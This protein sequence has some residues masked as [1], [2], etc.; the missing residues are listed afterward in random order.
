M[1]TTVA[2]QQTRRLSRNARRAVLIAHLSSAGAWLGVDLVMAVFIVR[3]GLTD[4]PAVRAQ[5][6]LALEVFA[7]W[8]LLVTGLVC[9]ATGVVLGLGTKWGLVRYWWVAAKLA[10]NVLLTGLVLVALRGQVDGAAG[11]SRLWLAGQPAD[12]SIGDYIYPPIVSPLALLVAFTLS[13]VKP[14]GRIR[15]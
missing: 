1:T 5:S 12:L 6:F 7:V 15:G 2:R 4:D 14:W 13:V 10:L 9:L 3:A 11:Q 8:P